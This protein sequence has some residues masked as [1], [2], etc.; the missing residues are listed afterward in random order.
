VPYGLYPEQV[1]DLR[2]TMNVGLGRMSLVVAARLPI[3]GRDELLAVARR[4]A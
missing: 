4:L 1:I 2:A 3:D